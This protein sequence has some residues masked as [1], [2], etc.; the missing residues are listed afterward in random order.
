MMELPLR[1]LP[2]LLLIA[3]LT[4]GAPVFA[5]PRDEAPE[6]M[7]AGPTASSVA[8]ELT[9]KTVAEDPPA[10]VAEKPVEQQPV[11]KPAPPKKDKK[12]QEKKKTAD[13]KAATAKESA[14]P[15]EPEAKKEA[16]AAA[17]ARDPVIVINPCTGEVS[18]EL[19]APQIKTKTIQPGKETKCLTPRQCDALC[20][21]GEA[22]GEGGGA[23]YLSPHGDVVFSTKSFTSFD[24]CVEA[25]GPK[26]K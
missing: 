14:P 20:R 11:K 2:A 9:A 26:C 16:P 7:P 21:V 24:D 5:Q 1:L 8:E 12:A 23:P 10:P 22:F 17:I 15:K 25:C 4:L 3:T 19:V 18:E 13:K 6:A